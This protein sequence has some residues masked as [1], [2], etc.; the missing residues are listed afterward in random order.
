M[1]LFLGALTLKSSGGGPSHPGGSHHH[2]QHPTSRG[3]V[4]NQ[5]T[6][7]QHHHHHNHHHHHHQRYYTDSIVAHN[8]QNNVSLS[9]PDL[10]LKQVLIV[11]KPKKE[12]GEKIAARDETNVE[13]GVGGAVL[14]SN[15]TSQF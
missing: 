4:N 1:I 12:A 7:Q 13:S 10:N 11:N 15:K 3:T 6:P 9:C 2:N 8:N 14:I 5:Q